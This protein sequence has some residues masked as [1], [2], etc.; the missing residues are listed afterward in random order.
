MTV[1][2]SYHGVAHVSNHIYVVAGRNEQGFD[3]TTSERYHIPTNKWER[4]D[5][6]FGKSG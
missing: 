6:Q 4:F 5:Y 1:G 3:D 2:R